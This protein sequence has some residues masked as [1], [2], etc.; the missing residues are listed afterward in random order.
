MSIQFDSQSSPPFCTQR[1]G[2]SENVRCQYVKCTLLHNL[3]PLYNS[4]ILEQ[5][6][7]KVMSVCSGDPLDYLLWPRLQS[8]PSCHQCLKQC[9]SRWQA[10]HAKS[11]TKQGQMEPA[12]GLSVWLKRTWRNHTFWMHKNVISTV[13][14]PIM[15]G[16][17]LPETFFW[18]AKVLVTDLKMAKFGLS[19]R[20]TRLLVLPVELS[21]QSQS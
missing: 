13:Y 14:C 8:L 12:L 9:K 7:M 15:P 4:A 16:F 17:C 6:C 21:Q 20:G 2:K 18:S 1:K 3:D 19:G 5:V 10:C 11:H